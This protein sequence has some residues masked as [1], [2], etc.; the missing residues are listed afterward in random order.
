MSATEVFPTGIVIV[1]KCR[2]VLVEGIGMKMEKG[3]KEGMV[4]K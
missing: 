1:S 4:E 2:L 3:K